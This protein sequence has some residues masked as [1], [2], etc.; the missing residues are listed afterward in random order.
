MEMATHEQIDVQE[1]RAV[2]GI[3]QEKLAETVGVSQPTV[4]LWESGKRN[5]SGS[6]TLLLKRLQQQAEK[7]SS[8]RA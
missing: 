6:A 4:A 5:P 7:K 2:L 8:K 3:T 1:I